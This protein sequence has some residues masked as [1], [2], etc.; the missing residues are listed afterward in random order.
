[1]IRILLHITLLGLL[2]LTPFLVDIL[3]QWYL[4]FAALIIS[5]YITAI[6]TNDIFG[7]SFGFFNTKKLKTKSGSYYYKIKT[8]S[9]IVYKE[10]CY[11]ILSEYRVMSNYSDTTE[12][13]NFLT[14]VKSIIDYEYDE[15][16]KNEKTAQHVKEELS[17]WK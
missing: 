5:V 7:N 16:V 11:W 3:S 2:I 14:E 15:R 10:Y 12:V 8:N 4:F 9:V 13:L 17:T 6:I 1:M